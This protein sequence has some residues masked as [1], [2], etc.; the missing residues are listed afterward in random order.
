MSRESREL[1]HERG[2]RDNAAMSVIASLKAWA[3]RLKSEITALYLAARH[4]ATPWYAKALV[5]AIV[6]YALSPI[7]LIPDFIP[8]LGFLDELVLLPLAIALAVKLIPSQ[9]LV[10]C[11]T[12]AVEI[13]RVD[14]KA[15]RVGAV[16]IALLWVVAVALAGVWMY[17]VLYD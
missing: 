5:I 16:L 3:R 14:S 13:G 17:R 8:V 10:E 9:V 7:D 6:A 15:G 1:K 12:R 4:P 2:S 11:R